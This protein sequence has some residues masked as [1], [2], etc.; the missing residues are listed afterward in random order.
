MHNN[1]GIQRDNWNSLLLN[2]INMSILAATTITAA[3]SGADINN[4]LPAAIGSTILFSAATG[5]LSIMNALQPSQLA[6]EQRNATRLFKH[7]RSQLQNKSVAPTESDVEDAVE[8]VLALDRAYPLP[9]LGGKMVPKFPAHFQPAAWWPQSSTCT[10][11]G[12]T[13]TGTGT[14]NGWTK[15]LEAE[16]RQVLGVVRGQDKEDYKK[17]GS[18]VLKLNK[19]LAVSGPALTGIAAAASAVGLASVA[20]GA[21][22]LATAVNTLEH[23]GQIGMV[24]EM[25]RNCAGF[26]DHMEESVEA[27]M[28]EKRENGRVLEMKVALGLGRS[29]SEL[30]ELASKC[31]YS[32]D[33]GTSLDEF[34]SKLF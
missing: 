29:P 17:L 10:G 9:L 34:A 19:V 25:Y 22:A 33:E 24:V 8:K 12:S 20:V 18:M 23:G 32:Q 2:S 26:F 28:E 14:G 13:G 4:H 31:S 30:R 3:T 5:L 1:V 21:G 15:E 16:M 6:E 11:T 27:S 7:L